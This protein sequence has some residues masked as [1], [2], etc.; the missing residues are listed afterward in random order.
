[1]QMNNIKEKNCFPY[2]AVFDRIL[3]NEQVLRAGGVWGRRFVWAG[4]LRFNELIHSDG[5][6]L[7]RRALLN[8]KKELPVQRPGAL[9][10]NYLIVD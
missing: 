7:R 1:M 5:L 9:F 8:F 2:L 4:G 6:R 3:A 10:I